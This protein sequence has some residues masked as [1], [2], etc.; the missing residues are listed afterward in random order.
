MVG[1]GHLIPLN[2]GQVSA[3]NPQGSRPSGTRSRAQ[4][5]PTMVLAAD[6]SDGGSFPWA[7]VKRWQ[8]GGAPF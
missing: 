8:T 3:M 6:W 5:S 7:G 2:G 4:S 1:Q